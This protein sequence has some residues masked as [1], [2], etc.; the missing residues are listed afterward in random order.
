MVGVIDLSRVCPREAAAQADNLLTQ[1][2]VGELPHFKKEELMSK[3]ATMTVEPSTDLLNVLKEDH[4]KVKDLF[5]RFKQTEDAEERAEIIKT[6]INELEVHAELEEKI[7]Y[8]AFRAHLEEDDLINAALE[9]HHVVH[10][11]I[12]ELKG[13]RGNTG[14]RDA[15][16][17]VLVEN[18]KHH[19]REEE[20]HLFPESL[21]LDLDWEA[22]SA[23]VEKKKAQLTSQKQPPKRQR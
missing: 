18:V 11:L 23:K 8:P 16:F 9:E 20:E 14:R 13:T 17:T 22:L 6:A 3:Q 21:V 15:K 19:I 12:D 2:R 5:E 7:V 1:L 4:Q 10:I